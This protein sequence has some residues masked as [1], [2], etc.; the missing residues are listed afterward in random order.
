MTLTDTQTTYRADNGNYIIFSESSYFETWTIITSDKR[1]PNK[2]IKNTY[3]YKS[4]L[5]A[6]EHMSKLSQALNVNID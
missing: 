6:T 5:D 1:G 2:T 4:V 3:S